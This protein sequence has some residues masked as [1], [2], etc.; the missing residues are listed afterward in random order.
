MLSIPYKGPMYH[1]RFQTGRSVSILPNQKIC[2]LCDGK[3]VWLNAKSLKVGM[4]VY[5]PH[6]IQGT[7]T[8][9]SINVID[10]I[11]QAGARLSGFYLYDFS[12]NLYSRLFRSSE[13]MRQRRR[14]DRYNWM[15]YKTMPANYHQLFTSFDLRAAT[16]SASHGA[17]VLC[18]IPVTESLAALF[19]YYIAEGFA[20][21]GGKEGRGRKYSYKV[22]YSIG[23]D[24]AQMIGEIR[25]AIHNI[26]KKA[27]VKLRPDSRS[28]GLELSISDKTLFYLFK[29]LAG[30]GAR[31]K[32][33]PSFIMNGDRNVQQAFLCAWVNGDAGATVSKTLMTEIQY[34][35]LLNGIVSTFCKVMRR[36]G[37]VLP[38]GGVTK[39]HVSYEMCFPPIAEAKKGAFREKRLSGEPKLIP[40]SGMSDLI[41]TQFKKQFTKP[42]TRVTA[43]LM[44][45][46]RQWR[47]ALMQGDQSSRTSRK[48]N[49]GFY[50]TAFHK[51]LLK[52]P[53]KKWQGQP[54][55]TVTG[56]NIV[57]EIDKIERLSNMDGAFIQLQKKRLTRTCKRNAYAIGSVDHN[58]FVCGVGGIFCSGGSVNAS[59][60]EKLAL[61]PW[62]HD[63]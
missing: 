19:G 15:K 36:E 9:D 63:L 29:Q 12:K 52:W 39:R 44:E 30:T 28:R 60:D 31:S 41:L 17:K 8:V 53:A 58:A 55:L 35:F 62:G 61:M 5:V 40:I 3:L 47:S 23:P 1:L 51:N 49:N 32:H 25:S 38:G 21:L 45:Y 24:D 4:Y 59:K 57:A 34:L 18:Q 37:D 43:P 50:R 16:V 2:V 54:E 46:L 14:W 20:Y 26:T 11:L 6:E 22:C 7:K 13:W 33:V 10:T 27:R 56:R 48:V 42:R